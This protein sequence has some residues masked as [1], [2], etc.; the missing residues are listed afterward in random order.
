MC[1]GS[2]D[3]AEEERSAFWSDEETIVEGLGE[4]SEDGLTPQGVSVVDSENPRAHLPNRTATDFVSGLTSSD[5]EDQV[6]Q[7]GTFEQDLQ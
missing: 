5:E 3:P 1:L 6:V 4:R 2:G 7:S